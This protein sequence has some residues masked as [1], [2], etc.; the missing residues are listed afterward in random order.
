MIRFRRKHA[1]M[2]GMNSAA[3]SF[4]MNLRI[5]IIGEEKAPY[6]GC[7]TN[8]IDGINTV[9]QTL[10]QTAWLR[11]CSDIRLYARI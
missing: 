3:D 5:H 7:A 2:R 11:V 6:N 10:F 9:L 4:I 1:I 8:I